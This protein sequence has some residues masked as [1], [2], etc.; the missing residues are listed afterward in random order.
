M[1]TRRRGG[2]RV[3]KAQRNVPGP[4]LKYPKLIRGRAPGMPSEELHKVNQSLNVLEC[5]EGVA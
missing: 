3:V 1:V 2:K 4:G 5:L